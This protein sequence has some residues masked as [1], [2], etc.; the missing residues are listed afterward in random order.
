MKTKTR[1]LLL[2]LLP[3]V[4]ALVTVAGLVWTQQEVSRAAR[5][6]KD[7][8]DII[9]RVF[10]L[11]Q[12]ITQD[13]LY[14][15]ERPKVQFRA[16]YASFQKTLTRLTAGPGGESLI[17]RKILSN[18]EEIGYLLNLV[19][20]PGGPSSSEAEGRYQQ[21]FREQVIGHLLIRLEEIVS[22]SVDLME[23]SRN[24][25]NG[26]VRWFNRAMMVVI[27]I[28][29]LVMA[30]LAWFIGQGILKNTRE[31][32]REID[33]RRAAEEALGRSELRYQIVADN[34]H[35]WE[36]WRSP[37]GRYLYVSPSCRKV[38]GHEPEEFIREADLLSRIVF[39][40]DLP[41]YKRHRQAEEAEGTG[42]EIQYRI[43]RPDG[44]LVWIG[45]VCKRVFDAEGRYLGIRGSNRDITNR[46]RMEEEIR[47]SHDEL[48]IRV[49]DRTR[50]LTVEIEER[51][52]IEGALRESQEELRRL[53]SR[54]LAA[55]E[56]ER[57]KVARDL[58]DQ[59]WQT[60]NRVIL[61]TN[62]LLSQPPASDW[63]VV[64]QTAETILADTREAIGR[65]RSMQGE[66]WPPVLDDLGI[67]PTLS[68]YLREFEKDHSG[69]ST[70]KQIEAAEEEVPQNI[71][72][73]IYRV[74]QEAL[75]NVAQHSG[76]GRVR[77]SLKKEKDRIVFAVNDDGKGFNLERI[78][79]GTQ[80]WVGFGLVGMKEKVEQSGG[81]FE[82][83]SREEAG[84][85]IQVSWPLAGPREEAP[86]KSPIR[87]SSQKSEDQF[88]VVTLA[89]SD[90]VY[91]FRV[92]PEGRLVLEWITPGFSMVT[93]YGLDEIYEE[94]DMSG[95]L[96]PDDRP[97]AEERS[98]YI[99]A[100]QTFTGEYRIITKSGA[101]RW[102]R[103]SF[104]PMADPLQP[105]TIR[106]VGAAQDITERKRTETALQEK[107]ALLEG[108]LDSVTESIVLLSPEGVFLQANATA[109]ARLEKPPE[110]VF[111][112]HASEVLPPD[113]V[114]SR[115]SRLEEV[116][117]SA[118][119]VEY[120][121]Q[122]AGL[123][124]QHNLYPVLDEQGQVMAVV[125]FSRDITEGRR[126]E[127]TLR[128]HEER[129][130]LF[131]DHSPTIAWIKDEQGRHVYL[132]KTYEERFGVR[133]EDWRGQT[134][135]ALWPAE[136]AAEFRRNDQAV[137]D[138]DRS[139]EVTEETLNP[140]GSRTFW[141][142]CKF[143]F[144]DQAGNRFV[145]GIGLDITD[146]QRA[147]EALVRL[148]SFPEQNPNP[149]LRITENGGLLYA[150]A[151]A[152]AW[153]AGGWG[154]QADTALPEPFIA[155]LTKASSPG[156]VVEEDITCPSGRSFWMTAVHP[157]NEDYV[158]FYGRDITLRKRA[159][160]EIQ[161]HLKELQIKNEELLRFNRVAVDRELRMIELKKEINELY[162]RTGQPVKY[163]LEFD[164]NSH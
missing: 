32:Q 59:T 91:A 77:L 157:P 140:D 18:Q 104:H 98:R 31:L 39:P 144:R 28:G 40:E 27:P 150:N 24:R 147:E 46:K 56:S 121:D 103:D 128:E 34:T 94:P 83:R 151:S 148:A 100:R 4:L 154:W 49:R 3:V 74:M 97:V 142:T 62:H 96:F 50:E 139:I 108:V 6:E 117:A 89:I 76:A 146:R 118:R 2:I 93:G 138:S 47:R 35:D 17:I 81:T 37:E 124:F 64:R 51:K 80:S 70:E 53:S 57:R 115:L 52:R 107:E 78:L 63:A 130:R 42:G 9:Q 5:I 129:F 26:A 71:K 106:V 44:A 141:L 19:L 66:L 38:T 113:L 79:S 61:E 67:L 29:G 134:D 15:E 126:A 87:L 73:V 25:M 30:L 162:A 20:G 152:R 41:I 119:P 123:L 21:E 99:R 111:G 33:E 132:S 1:V 86:E 65:I 153:L 55:Q 90:W 36:F 158:T 85:I 155:L 48:E 92:E 122:R 137:L 127:E 136:I 22:N 88:R 110:A 13:L 120:E 114:R 10:E 101:I 82:I 160:N 8:D 102:I 149:V 54:I 156:Q 161:R 75:K 116:V 7:S 11:N 112:R 164:I 68:W 133:L 45:H 60:L 16:I 163:K 58:H 23:T 14:Q 131:M 143:P 84:T 72:I 125:S 95:F 12:V 159:E 69:F 105:E 43:I 145:A 135:A 109:M